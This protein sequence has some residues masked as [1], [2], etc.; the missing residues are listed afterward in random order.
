MQKILFL[1]CL[2]LPGAAFADSPTILSGPDLAKVFDDQEDPTVTAWGPF[3]VDNYFVWPNAY[4]PVDQAA[5]DNGNRKWSGCVAYSPDVASASSVTM[6]S[7]NAGGI[8]PGWTVTMNRYMCE[9][10]GQ[11]YYLKD[12][13]SLWYPT[14]SNIKVAVGTTSV[15]C[16]GSLGT[17]GVA[18]ASNTE[19]ATFATVTPMPDPAAP[20]II[21]R[22]GTAGEKSGFPGKIK[23]LWFSSQEP[24]QTLWNGQR[25][26]FLANG[27][28]QNTPG[29]TLLCDP[30]NYDGAV[31]DC[32]V[33]GAFITKGTVPYTIK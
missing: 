21:G 12:A 32:T 26:H 25:N 3:S 11:L 1:L 20:L 16:F 13:T 27:R 7:N 5:D 22:K 29:T 10:C 15:F 2:I 8:F 4:D 17:G 24:T 33:G 30:D 31:L 28:F 9:G 14:S 23:A 18:S 19:W 6:M